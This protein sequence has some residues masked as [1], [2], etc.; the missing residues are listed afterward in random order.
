MKLGLGGAMLGN[1]VIGA[2]IGDAGGMMLG[3][4]PFIAGGGIGGG[5]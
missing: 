3:A 5:A 2:P 1:A 4:G